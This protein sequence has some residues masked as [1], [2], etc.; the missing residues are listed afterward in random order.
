[1]NRRTRYAPGSE[2]FRTIIARCGYNKTMSTANTFAGQFLIA[3]PSIAE[4]PFARGVAFVC[5]HGEDGA[6]G[7]LINQMSEYRLGDVL[8]QMKLPCEDP[9]IADHAVLIGGPVQQERGFVL[10]REHGHWD[11]SYRIDE[12]WSVTTSRDILVAMARGDGPRRAVVTLG[13][14]GWEAGQL[15]QEVMENAWLNSEA[16]ERIIFETPIEERWFAATRK[17]GVRDPSQLTGYAG[18]A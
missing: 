8:A 1:V 15:E 7:L 11:S 4:P 12:E 6:V 13:Y 3:M 17:M 5:Q 2:Q 16:D 18:H 10:H 14:A 9:E